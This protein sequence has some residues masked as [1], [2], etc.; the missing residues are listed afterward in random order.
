MKPNELAAGTDDDHDD[1]DDDDYNKSGGTQ[2][3]KEKNSI[4]NPSIENQSFFRCV[5]WSGLLSEPGDY[6]SII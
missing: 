2:T 3:A 4:S 5:S 6:K 1:D